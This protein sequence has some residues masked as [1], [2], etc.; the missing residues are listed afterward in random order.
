MAPLSGFVEAKRDSDQAARVGARSTLAD[1]VSLVFQDGLFGANLLQ[2]CNQQHPPGA[3]AQAVPGATGWQNVAAR[4]PG[5]HVRRDVGR[6]TGLREREG[7]AVSWGELSL[8]D[9][10]SGVRGH[11]DWP[12][13]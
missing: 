7:G 11:G 6:S 1:L 12:G 9:Q 13:R 3:R 5:G 4:R 10:E 8:T 2:L